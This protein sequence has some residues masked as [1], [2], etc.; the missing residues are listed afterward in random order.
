MLE[1]FKNNHLVM[2][3]EEG[4]VDFRKTLFLENAQERFRPRLVRIDGYE[5]TVFRA[6]SPRGF[7]SNRYFFTLS[8]DKKVMCEGTFHVK[9]ASPDYTKSSGE[10]IEEFMFYLDPASKTK[11]Y[12]ALTAIL[13]A[14][15]NYRKRNV[16]RIMTISG[17]VYKNSSPD[18]YEHMIRRNVWTFFVG[19][20]FVPALDI[21]AKEHPMTLMEAVTIARRQPFAAR[22]T[23]TAAN[24]VLSNGTL[25]LHLPV[26]RGQGAREMSASINSQI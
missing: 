20:G 23:K 3:G 17:Q 4:P 19:Q 9:I 2:L 18:F 11:G 7:P 24:R 22:S 8:K 25:V 16:S 5:W 15:Y 13:G 1:F 10:I 26:K 14:I 12:Q 21:T 6:K